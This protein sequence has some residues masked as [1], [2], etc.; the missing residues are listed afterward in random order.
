[1]IH[2]QCFINIHKVPQF[3][4]RISEITHFKQVNQIQSRIRFKPVLSNQQWCPGLQG[5][6]AALNVSDFSEVRFTN[7]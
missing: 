7:T 3:L 6:V 5:Q 1:M 4:K 2:R